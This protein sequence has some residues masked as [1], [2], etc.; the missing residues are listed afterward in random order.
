MKPEKDIDFSSDLNEAV[1][2]L[3]NGGII[4]YPTDTVWGIGCDA[5]NSEA[6]KKIYSLKKRA[7]NKS[8][9]VL[10]NTETQLEK[11]VDEIPEITWDLLSVAVNPITIIYDKAHGV[12]QEL[13]AQ[14]GS[15]GIRIT[16]ERFSNEV[17]KQLGGPIVSTS[18]NL[19]GEKSPVF[20][21]EI[22]EEIKKGVDYIVKYRQKDY[23]RHLPSNI[24]K[25][26]KG[27]TV[28][29]IR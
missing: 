25:L 1:N 20:F 12:A 2:C 6:V 26:G 16:H 19:S 28:T 14:D 22:S 23:T 15:L 10:V 13:I 27:G 18:A 17:C 21:S 7:N 11:L 24:I 8:M 4:L 3:K 5:K 9:L 29:I